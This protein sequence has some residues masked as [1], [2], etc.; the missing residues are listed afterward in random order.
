MNLFC[1]KAH[2]QSRQ[3]GLKKQGVNKNP[4]DIQRVNNI[5]IIHFVK[6]ERQKLNGMSSL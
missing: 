6:M 4:G 3:G 5:Q 1:G 2:I